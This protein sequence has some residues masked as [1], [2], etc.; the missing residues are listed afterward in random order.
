MTT[1][2]STTSPSTSTSA[3][4]RL[5]DKARAAGSTA[6]TPA[7]AVRYL[8]GLLASRAA[9][10][11]GVGTCVLGHRLGYEGRRT[12][13]GTTRAAWVQARRD[14]LGAQRLAAEGLLALDE[15]EEYGR[16]LDCEELTRQLRVGGRGLADD[17]ALRD[18]WGW[19]VVEVEEYGRYSKGWHRKYGPARSKE[20]RLDVPVRALREP[21]GAFARHD[22]P[23]SDDLLVLRA[24]AVTLAQPVPGVTRAWQAV[25]AVRGRGYA[26]TVSTMYV[27]THADGT[28]IHADTLEQLA[29]MA[30]RRTA[31]AASAA[32]RAAKGLRP[33]AETMHPVQRRIVALYR[34]RAVRV[35]AQDSYAAGNCRAGTSAWLAAR[36]LDETASL[37]VEE[38]LLAV[39]DGLAVGGVHQR[40]AELA[41][42]AAEAAVRR[43]RAE[44]ATAQLAA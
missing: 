7:G 2:T 39:L 3:A 44:A 24:D 16:Q 41:L 14:L 20:T 35:R 31:R 5:L 43:A 19:R 9:A 40:E 33:D 17:V 27:A 22:C 38:V 18:T 42:R 10:A 6:T 34:H 26:R 8:R 25:V 15:A 21:G 29:A 32:K 1:P 30:Q 11:S 36:D 37:T 28:V 13:G 23:S 4:Q 12:S